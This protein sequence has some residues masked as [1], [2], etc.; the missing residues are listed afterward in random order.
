[1]SQSN[2]APRSQGQPGPER[3]P[4]RRHRRR[5]RSKTN[6]V[7]KVLGTLLLVGVTTG[8][9]LVC[10]AAIYIRTVIMPEAAKQDYMGDMSL[11]LTSTMYYTD[12]DGTAQPYL[13]LSSDQNRVWVSYKD[14]PSD[15]VKALIAIEDKRFYDHKGVDWLRTGKGVLN[16]FTGGSIQG[17]STIT[18]QLI[19]NTTGEKQATVKRKITEIFRAL[20]FEKNH[21][22]E[23]ILEQYL[24]LVYFGE[25]CYG[26]GAASWAYF[27]KDVRELDLAQCASLVGITNN[28]SRYDPYLNK[29]AEVTNEEANRK[30][31]KLVLWNMFDQKMIDEETYET[32][33]DEVDRL[34]FVMG[35]AEGGGPTTVY[36]WYQDQVIDDV[37]NDL[38]DE[39][40]WSR[41]VATNKVYYGGLSIYTNVDLR[42]QGIVDEVYSDPDNLPYIS[43]SGQQMQSGMVIIDNQGRV[44]ALSG[45]IGDKTKNRVWSRASATKRP[46]GSS[47]KPL[48][49]YAPAVEMGLLNPNTVL[50][51]APYQ[52]LGGSPWPVNAVGYYKGLD[53]VKNAVAQSHN[54]IA[55][56]VLGDYVTPR[57]SYEFLEERFHISS[58]VLE[59]WINN[60]KYS[61]MDLAPLALGGLT[62]GVSLYEMAAAYATFPSMGRYVPPR[63]YSKVVDT[64]GVTVLL[65]RTG[66]GEYVLKERTAY[67]MNSMLQ[68][69]VTSGTGR[70]AAFSGMTI[71][72]KTG[73]TTSQKDLWFI[74]YTPYY[75][76]AVWVGYD[77]Q[78]RLGNIGHPQN[79]LWKKVMSRVHEGLENRGFP[80]PSDAQV[81]TA[82]Y[83]LDSGLI[84]TELCQ[85]DSRGSRVAT[86]TFL[87][88]DQPTRYCD[89]HTQVDVCTADP[90][91][92]PETG[93][94][95]GRYHLAGPYCPADTVKT[96]GVVD[97]TREGAAAKVSVRDYNAMLSSYDPEDT[98]TVH[99]SDWTPPGYGEGEGFDPEDP[100]T[101][102]TGDPDFKIDDPSTWPDLPQPDQPT[103]HPGTTPSPSPAP[104]PESSSQPSVWVPP[105]SRPSTPAP[106][107]P[108]DEPYVPA[109]H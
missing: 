67:Y 1:M 80:N 51:D 25:R 77:R 22:K 74:G 72:G 94:A 59:K 66:D 39:Y 62:N 75:T 86:G 109:V 87:S 53:T 54:T 9:L 30:R 47:I 58:L 16:M 63:T 40:G 91:L 37:V 12:S 6:M 34:V 33:C 38:M 69:V 84:P 2:Q 43:N 35:S 99:G 93:E 4:V 65:D 14:L 13:T 44:V 92:D 76:G 90:I 55:V 102:P 57:A 104:T 41:Q 68:G 106:A 17:G 20:E 82:S 56:Q 24:N 108:G 61:D 42:I 8:V 81:V 10:F 32:A 18:Q 79:L 98:C 73:T 96:I 50:D 48:S 78:E 5:R 88:G 7:W 85:Q 52:E 11:A 21:S 26:V 83:C 46:S 3:R 23:Q 15:L 28:P 95:T 31:A 29:T 45:G 70:D 19:K 64:D 103:S 60:R 97:Y 27:G 105:I 49:V 89:R 101:W 71:A 107:V 100:S 36:N